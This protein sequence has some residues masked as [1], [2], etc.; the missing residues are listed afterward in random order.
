[1]VLIVFQDS[2]GLLR[3]VKGYFGFLGALR[4]PKDTLGLLRSVTG[5]L[6][7]DSLSYCTF[8]RLSPIYSFLLDVYQM[9]T[10][11]GF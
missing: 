6:M 5:R 2:L 10:V 11:V 3:V 4:I 8:H 9:T 7:T 1:M